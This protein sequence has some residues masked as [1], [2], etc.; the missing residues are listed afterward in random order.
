VARCARLVGY[1]YSFAAAVFVVPPVAAAAASAERN[2]VTGYAEVN[3]TRLYYESGGPAADAP[4]GG[5]TVVF[6]GVGSGMDHRLW[7]D[8]FGFFSHDFRAVRYDV[9]G[10]GQSAQPTEPF[11]PLDDLAALLD[12]LEIEKDCLVGLSLGGQLAIDFAL[13]HPDRVACLVLVAPGLG[14]YPYSD[15]FQQRVAPFIAA[16]QAGETERLVQMMLDDPYLLPAIKN[17]AA[18][19]RA[20]KIWADNARP[21]D[22]APIALDPPAMGR[23]GE[24]HVPTLLVLGDRDWKDLYEIA[25]VLEREVPGLRRVT[26]PGSGHTVNMEMPEEFNRAVLEFLKGLPD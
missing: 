4:P 18:R 26:I 22:V 21:W 12:F 23:L 11:S 15:E 8:Q 13:A 19:E 16:M 17:P 3:G 7:D 10:V 5:A 20:K 6:I 9:R 14:G 2:P 1:L 25:D 24:I